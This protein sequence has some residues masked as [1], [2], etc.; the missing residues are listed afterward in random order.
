M[1][2][3]TI[4]LEVGPVEGITLNRPA[5]LNALNATVRGEIMDAVD[6]LAVDPAV[7]GGI[8]HGA[9]EKAIVAGADVEEFAARMPGEQ[10]EVYRHRRVYDALA[11][12]PKPMIA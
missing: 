6:R 7:K 12:F 2:Y 11:D 3:E 1:S 10:R 8:V 9:G 5:K 4:L